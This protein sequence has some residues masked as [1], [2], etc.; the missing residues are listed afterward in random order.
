MKQYHI[1]FQ[2][3]DA[4]SGWQPRKQECILYADSSF[5]ARLKCI[6]LYGL[7]TDCDYRIDSVEE[8]GE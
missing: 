7:G 1:K 4:M 2:Y 6:E 5:N 3:A 8:I